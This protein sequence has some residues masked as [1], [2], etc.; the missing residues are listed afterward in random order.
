[1]IRSTRS[2]PHDGSRS[3]AF[4][5]I[6]I[7]IAM[8][9]IAVIAAVAVPTLQGLNE[10]EKLREP[11]VTLADM[12]REVRQR[13]IRE[14][15]QYEIVFER[16]GVHAVPGNRDFPKRDEFLKYLEELRSPP[17][18]TEFD[19]QEPEKITVDHNEAAQPQ[20]VKPLTAKPGDET[21]QDETGKPS[22]PEMPWTQTIA[23]GN[24]MKAAVLF[25]GDGEWDDLDGDRL[26]R[27]VFQPNGMAS[28]MQ[29]RLVTGGTQLEAAFDLLTGEML[30][31]R[32]R[33]AKEIQP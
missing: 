32:S 24:G 23:V 22:E 18:I 20:G 28:P 8:T 16:D 3:G 6:E 7:I 1:M 33:P 4:T 26:R 29:V 13:A 21:K 12:V 25:W 31:E 2:G 19:R 27:W 9:I 5:L 10:E 30:H 17:E 14:H 15:R 11:L